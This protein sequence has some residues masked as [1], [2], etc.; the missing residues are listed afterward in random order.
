MSGMGYQYNSISSAISTILKQ[1]GFMGLYKGITP[2]LLKVAPSMAASWWTFEFVRD[3]L[4]T[5]NPDDDI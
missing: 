4:V 5:L 2:N 1:E 3:L